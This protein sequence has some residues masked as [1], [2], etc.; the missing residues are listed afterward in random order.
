[1]NDYGKAKKEYKKA[2]RKA[3]FRSAF[4]M[5]AGHGTVLAGESPVMGNL[6]SM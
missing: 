5:C 3:K 1:V 2:L 4:M 6:P